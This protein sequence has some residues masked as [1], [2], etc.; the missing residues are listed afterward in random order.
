MEEL[1]KSEEELIC[2]E[3]VAAKQLARRQA[4]RTKDNVC[5]RMFA[6]ESFADDC[7]LSFVAGNMQ[8]YA[9]EEEGEW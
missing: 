3:R 1:I 2:E 7:G 9:N 8:D 4:L 5:A 6:L